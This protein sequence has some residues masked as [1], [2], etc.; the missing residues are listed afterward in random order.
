MIEQTA[1]LT[2]PK[3][4]ARLVSAGRKGLNGPA[5]VVL[6]AMMFQVAIA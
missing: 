2:A 4:I 1:S 5:M 3:T 6:R